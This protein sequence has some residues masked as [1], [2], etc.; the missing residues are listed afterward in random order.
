MWG[1]EGKGDGGTNE[2]V[3]GQVGFWPQWTISEHTSEDGIFL[4]GLD[5]QAWSFLNKHQCGMSL[6]DGVVLANPW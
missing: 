3:D 5:C 1:V 6:Q 4:D 2:W